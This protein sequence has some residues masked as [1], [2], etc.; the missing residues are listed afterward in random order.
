MGMLAV[1]STSGL[2]VP[3]SISSPVR[4]GFLSEPSGYPPRGLAH[5]RLT[6]A[7]RGSLA[8]PLARALRQLL[9]SGPGLALGGLAH[10]PASADQP[11]LPGVQPQVVGHA[12]PPYG[13]T[14]SHRVLPLRPVDR[15]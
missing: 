7:I 5:F 14:P 9:A 3:G 10:Q 8:G 15:K 13:A 1:R 2:L 12:Q 11:L 4:L 6:A